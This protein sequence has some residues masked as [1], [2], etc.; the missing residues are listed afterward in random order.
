MAARKKTPARKI[1]FNLSAT[2]P[3]PANP[4]MAPVPEAPAPAT[5]EQNPTHYHLRLHNVRVIE[6]HDVRS[7]YVED[8]GATVRIEGFHREGPTT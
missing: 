2:A 3:T 8:E 5:A 4:L 7:V 1:T 6:V